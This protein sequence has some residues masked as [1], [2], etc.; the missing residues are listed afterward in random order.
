MSKYWQVDEKITFKMY[1]GQSRSYLSNRNIYTDELL[2][3]VGAA[4]QVCKSIV[5]FLYRYL[6]SLQ[7]LYFVVVYLINGIWRR[8]HTPYD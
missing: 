7:N 2:S 5:K 8:Q 6:T 1:K 4:E 3:W